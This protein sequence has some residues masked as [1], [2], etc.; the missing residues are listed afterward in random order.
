MNKK[1]ELGKLCSNARKVYE[2]SLDDVVENAA[3]KG[4]QLS[5][6]YL[7]KIENNPDADPKVSDLKALAAGLNLP[8]ESVFAAARGGK[9][10]K[11]DLAIEEFAKLIEISK[12]WSEEDLKHAIEICKEVFNSFHKRVK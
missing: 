5:K 7:S 4:F 9:L 10:N 3:S 11:E 8:E 6:S 12:N 2:L 1:S